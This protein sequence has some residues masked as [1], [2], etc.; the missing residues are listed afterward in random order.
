MQAEQADLNRQV[1]QQQL[2]IA[3]DQQRIANETYDYQKGTF[4]PV[5]QAIADEAM[6]FN[7]GDYANRKA[8]QAAADTQQAFDQ[9]GAEVNRDLARRGMS[10]SAGQASASASDLALRKAAAIAAESNSAREQ[11]DAVG[12]AR[13]MDAASIGRNLP[14]QQATA[15]QIALSGGTQASGVQASTAAGA[16]ADAG[17]I[18]TGFNTNIGANQAAGQLYAQS[19]QQNQYAAA[20]N[21]QN[22]GQ[23]FGTLAGA[24]TSLGA[25]AILASSK[26]IKKDR[27]PAS[28][29]AASL[30][31]ES[32]P[33]EH[34]KYDERKVPELADG[35][36]HIGPMAQ[37]FAKH[38]GGDGQ[39]INLGDEVGTLM[40]SQKDVLRRV[41][42]LEKRA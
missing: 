1:M 23:L 17:V 10:M 33:V 38:V 5:E 28:P 7:T 27:A 39:T 11:A 35:R 3:N 34:W 20:Q 24:A 16:R 41:K 14:S 2:D 42:K 19:S 30:A 8:A 31:I 40:A 29:S 25:A 18:G 4:R 26:D 37:D 13:K 12:F 9:A 36:E 6:Q 15:A 21:A 22:S 32:M